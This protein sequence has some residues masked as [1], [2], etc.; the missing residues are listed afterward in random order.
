VHLIVDRL[1][2]AGNDGPV[3]GFIGNMLIKLHYPLA[4]C[5]L[6]AILCTLVYLAGMPFRA[7]RRKRRS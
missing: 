5:A 2:H 6:S 7:R 3:F 1:L 4:I